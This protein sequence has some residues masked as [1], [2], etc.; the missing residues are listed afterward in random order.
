MLDRNRAGCLEH[1][2]DLA[3]QGNHMY[4]SGT[5]YCPR[6][7]TAPRKV[8]KS[9]GGMSRRRRD[10]NKDDVIRM[11]INSKHIIPNLLFTDRTL[12]CPVLTKNV[13][14]PP[15]KRVLY[16]GPDYWK[17]LLYF[18]PFLLISAAGIYSTIL[19]IFKPGGTT[20][21]S[22]A[23]T[24]RL[25]ALYQICTVPGT[26]RGTLHALSRWRASAVLPL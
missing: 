6:S 4:R 15:S 20:S 25:L 10:L 11:P 12:S 13:L 17:P 14:G 5:H 2:S 19:M 23:R 1:A 26:E 3:H 22:Q 21:P 16:A 9:G 18:R 8:Y 7:S 24:A